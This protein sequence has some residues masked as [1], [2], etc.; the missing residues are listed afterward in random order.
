MKL[1]GLG[2]KIWVNL[3]DIFWEMIVRYATE[4]DVLWR[5]EIETKYESLRGLRRLWGHLEWKFGKLQNLEVGGK[6][7][8]NLLSMRW[9]MGR[10]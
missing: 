4:S 6:H 9:V 8:Q 5:L 10:M 3:I 7:F 1:G 2:L